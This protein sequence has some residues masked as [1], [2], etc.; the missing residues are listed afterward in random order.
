MLLLEAR[1]LQRT[2]DERSRTLLAEAAEQLVRVG[3]LRV[4]ALAR[5]DLG[6]LE[7]DHREVAHALQHLRQALAVLLELDRSGAAVAVAALSVVASRR[8]RSRVADRLAAE[9]FSIRATRRRAVR[10]ARSADRA[11]PRRLR[12]RGRRLRPAGL[13][14]STGPSCSRSSTTSDAVVGPGATDLPRNYRA[15]RGCGQAVGHGLIAKRT[16]AARRR[17]DGGGLPPVVRSRGCRGDGGVAAAAPAAHAQRRAVTPVPRRGVL[18]RSSGARYAFAVV[19]QAARRC[20]RTD[21]RGAWAC[22]SRSTRLPRRR[23]ASSLR[24]AVRPNWLPCTGPAC[25]VPRRRRGR[26]GGRPAHRGPL[27]RRPFPPRQQRAPAA[28]A[29]GAR[30]RSGRHRGRPEHPDPAVGGRGARGGDLGEDRHVPPGDGSDRRD[31]PV[32]RVA[33]VVVAA[34]HDATA[35]AHRRRRGAGA[36]GRVGGADHAAVPARRGGREAGGQQPARRDRSPARLRVRDLRELALRRLRRDPAAAR[37]PR[38]H[39]QELRV[40]RPRLRA[41]SWARAKTSGS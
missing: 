21:A 35:A 22:R 5:L 39:R 36:D 10:G 3:G 8:G 30:G 12:R 37:S 34:R 20:I 38:G 33:L 29:T 26:G 40:L 9:A 2:G 15:L 32:V 6:V 13:T 19:Q 11:T 31:R 25:A 7:L 24:P 17:Y 1:V 4:A 23:G 28:E 14:S 18:V 27:V 16:G 41:R